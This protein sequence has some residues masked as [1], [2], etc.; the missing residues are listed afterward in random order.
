[1]APSPLK[2]TGQW[3]FSYDEAMCPLLQGACEEIQ[4]GGY[5]DPVGWKKLPSNWS[6]FWHWF[7]YG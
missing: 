3:L 4:R 5:A 1:M 7:C 2:R 6:E